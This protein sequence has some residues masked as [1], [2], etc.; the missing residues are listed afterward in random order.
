M[1][2]FDVRAMEEIVSELTV[3]FETT[4]GVEYAPVALLLAEDYVALV[5]GLGVWV[6]GLGSLLVDLV[7][8]EISG[9]VGGVGFGV[10]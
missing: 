8:V 2:N 5:L 3:N 4:V 7:V 1:I 10:D 6:E 9:E